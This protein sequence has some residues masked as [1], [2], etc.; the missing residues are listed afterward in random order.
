M[1]YSPVTHRAARLRNN[2]I[3]EVTRKLFTSDDDRARSPALATAML[4]VSIG[5]VP[6]AARA[7]CS[8]T[9]GGSLLAD[10][11][12]TCVA[13]GSYTGAGVTAG[14]GVITALSGGVITGTG[15]LTLTMT[16]LD[17][18]YATDPGSQIDLQAGAAITGA[19]KANIG[20][21]AANG[22]V[23]T[24]GGPLMIDLPDG[25]GNS[26]VFVHD[27]GSRISLNGPVD[28]TMG[29]G[30][31]YSPGMLVKGGATLVAN[32]DVTIHTAGDSR[33]DAIA[34]DTSGQVTL[35]GTLNFTTTG[36]QAA[37]LKVSTTANIGYSGQAT[38]AVN[39]INGSGIRAVTG[40]SV[41]ASASSTTVINVTGVNGAGI[42]S[43]DTGSQVNLAG[44]TRIDV[45]AATQANFPNGNTESYA[46]GLLSD[47]GGMISSTG[48]L[49]LNTT[50]ATSY[51]A[52]LLRDGASIS[53]TGGGS[54]RS[55]GVAI[56][57]LSGANQTASFDK[58]D[59]S[60]T[61]GDLIQ[62]N[63]AT[64]SSA[65]SLANSSAAAAAGSRLMSV[66][67][68]STFTLDTDH[69]TLSG[70]MVA[71]AG[72]AASVNL[73][74]SSSLSGTIDGTA[75]NV[76]ATSGWTMTG[77][78]TLNQLALAGRIDFQA[79]G[80]PFAARN[81]T[82]NGDWIGQGGTVKLYTVLGDSNS[83]SDRIVINGGAASGH[84][85]LQVANV[86]G[87]GAATTGNG[88]LLVEATNG[89][90]T[91]AQ[92]SKDAFSLYRGHVD[93]G[94]YE[95]RLHAADAVGA[96]ENWY[97][98]S[99][100]RAEVPLATALAAQ[101]RQSSLA[102]LGN[103]HRRSG[104]ET[105]D[106]SDHSR[107]AWARAVY[108]DLDIRQGDSVDAQ[109]QGHVS[110]LQV[111]T[112]LLVQGN[113]HA[114]LYIGA[115]EGAADVSA[116]ARGTVGQVGNNALQ[117]QHIAGYATWADASGLYA[118]AVVQADQHSYTLRPDAGPEASGQATGFSASLEVGKSYPLN[119]GWSI[120]P[121]AQLILQQTHIDD[122]QIS[123][124]TI[125]QHTTSG[126]IGRLGVRIKD[127][128]RTTAGL[129]QPY[130]RLN[131]YSASA[132]TDATD[133]IAQTTT[134][135]F[136]STSGYSSVELAAG[137]TLALTPRT[138]LYGELGHVFSAGGDTEI[139]S[140][141]Q[142]SVGLRMRW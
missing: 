46:A 132:G 16:G 79:P 140:P 4:A 131:L 102:M 129:F 108:S 77:N 61:S 114:G 19:G 104:D 70:D 116:R 18:A 97:L 54:I 13:S 98:R 10:A 15:P 118:D 139:K 88:I 6:H 105:S 82:V 36:Q 127:S 128:L 86:D 34:A 64:G 22:G 45:N 85:T 23:I 109:S 137:F 119:E 126:A 43:R 111:G 48:A 17:G 24:V 89:A 44:S 25:S 110:G 124:A 40:G 120:E 100:Y 90:T 115:L 142:G 28:I 9:S 95:Y 52:L 133:F 11:G 65:L 51:G 67:G 141:V 122:L 107:R 138:D 62:V 123:G 101:L 60:N 75:L 73:R 83:P 21:H 125:Q 121:Q 29:A 8:T 39:G 136:E 50:D 134:T 93:A 130:A 5:L 53:A 59:I 113:W 71:D 81:L 57:F 1:K 94:A 112:D 106:T 33:S 66:S 27:S 56:G 72:S 32:G 49:Q 20:L 55:A 35:N 69:S 2:P 3:A 47:A 63:A 117:S 99:E 14:N 7:A 37:G 42:S 78:S 12:S 76:D 74:K 68:G 84:T 92:G 87:L 38:F 135:R 31:I 58:F 103:L 96:G 30:H 91:T 41:N 26:G 80:T